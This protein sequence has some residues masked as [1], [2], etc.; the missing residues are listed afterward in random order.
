MFIKRYKCI[1]I[2]LILFISISTAYSQKRR[3]NNKFVQRWG[4][5]TAWLTQNAPFREFSSFQFDRIW[6]AQGI[7]TWDLGNA[8]M[9]LSVGFAYDI[10]FRNRM[11]FR[12][13]GYI[14]TT[15]WISGV[16]DIGTGIRI[17]VS[18]TSFFSIEAYF[19]INQT[20]GTLHMVGAPENALPD[21]LDFYMGLFG[22]KFRM[23]F[24][25]TISKNYFLTPYISY[26][27]Y[28]WY[29]TNLDALFYLNGFSKGSLIDSMQVGFEFGSRF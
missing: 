24:E 19:S 22:F 18:R 4:V 3:T 12:I 28:P 6:Y 23:A 14:E 25:F 17:P 5:S 29:A 7:D 10:T 15:G 8:A 20:G 21:T 9:G 2:L 1:G 27:G 13:Q 11:M 16:F 26:A